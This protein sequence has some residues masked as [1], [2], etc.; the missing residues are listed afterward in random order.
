MGKV[1]LRNTKNNAPIRAMNPDSETKIEPGQEKEVECDDFE[2]HIENGDAEVVETE[3]GEEP[4]KEPETEGIGLILRA[5]PHVEDVEIDD[6][7]GEYGKHLPTIQEEFS[8]DWASENLDGIGPAKAEDIAEKL[9]E[10]S[11]EIPEEYKP[12]DDGEE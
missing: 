1:T 9:P 3:D 10:L 11:E 12:E 4:D 8:E 6:I 2:F 7:I 5:L